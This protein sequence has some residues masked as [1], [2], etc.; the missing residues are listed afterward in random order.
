MLWDPTRQWTLSAAALHMATDYT[1]YEGM[2]VTGQPV[3]AIVGGRVVVH[4]GRLIDGTPG[5]GT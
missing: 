4:E 1:P 3:T 5:A 2:T